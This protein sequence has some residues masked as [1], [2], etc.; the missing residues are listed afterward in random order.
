MTKNHRLSQAK[1]AANKR[2]AE[3]RGTHPT[4]AKTLVIECHEKVK[5]K[6]ENVLAFKEQQVERETVSLNED[7]TD[8][9]MDMQLLSSL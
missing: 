8:M 9:H 3:R 6:M 4:P 1:I 7:L 5:E 2:K